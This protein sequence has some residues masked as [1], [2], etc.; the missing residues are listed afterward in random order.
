MGLAVPWKNGLY[1]IPLRRQTKDR[2]GLSSGGGVP[3]EA[4]GSPPRP[5]DGKATEETHW[6]LL[7]WDP[8]QG[9]VG[10][11]GTLHDGLHSRVQWCWGL[12]HP[13]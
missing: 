5:S 8:R 2:L 7:T 10:E 1:S 13:W 9:W 11:A 4:F 12:H 3:V 6:I